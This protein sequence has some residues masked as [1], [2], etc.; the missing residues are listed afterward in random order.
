MVE[1]TMNILFHMSALRTPSQTVHFSICLSCTSVHLSRQSLSLFLSHTL[2]PL[3]F[4][5][6]F[7]KLCHERQNAKASPFEGVLPDHRANKHPCQEKAIWGPSLTEPELS[8]ETHS[9]YNGQRRPFVESLG[10]AGLALDQ[11]GLYVCV[12]VCTFRTCAGTHTHTYVYQTTLTCESEHTHTF[13]HTH[14][15]SQ[16]FLISLNSV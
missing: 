16:T 15:E 5:F 10:A 6:F 12:C 9:S 4:F 8:W 2:Q 14:T 11:T 13:A 3:F 7:Q 1:N